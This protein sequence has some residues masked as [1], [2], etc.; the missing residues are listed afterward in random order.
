MS[1]NSKIEWTDVQP[2]DASEG[3]SG[4]AAMSIQLGKRVVYRGHEYTVTAFVN[5]G[6]RIESDNYALVVHPEDL[7]E[8]PKP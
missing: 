7:K 4:G 5:W 2:V 8:A 1:E 3:V 6:V